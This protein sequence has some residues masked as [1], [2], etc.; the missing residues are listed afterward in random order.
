MEP[1][2]FHI[3]TFFFKSYTHF[4]KIPIISQFPIISLPSRLEINT[5]E[6][7]DMLKSVELNSQNTT[8]FINSVSH[9][10]LLV[11]PKYFWNSTHE[12]IH[13]EDKRG[14]SLALL[15]KTRDLSAAFST[16]E[17]LTLELPDNY[18]E[19]NIIYYNTSIATTADIDYMLQ[20]KNAVRLEI[21]GMPEI[22]RAL[23]QRIDEMKEMKHLRRLAFN[24]NSKV[25][26]MTVRPFLEKLPVLDSVSFYGPSLTDEELETFAHSQ[27]VDDLVDWEAYC[28]YGHKEIFYRRQ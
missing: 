17:N 9:P 23:L 22:S 21:L 3:S 19:Y 18:R 14:N 24:I 1:Q 13:F 12:S 4:T 10:H 2:N 20:W 8:I 15:P 16:G 5:Q 27:D 11:E 25:A 26:N 7:Y 6:E 28:L